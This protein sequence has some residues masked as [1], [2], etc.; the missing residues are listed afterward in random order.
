MNSV[1]INELSICNVLLRHGRNICKH[2][3][4]S[5]HPV[6][7]G[8]SPVFLVQVSRARRR[9]RRLFA[10]RAREQR[11]IGFFDRSSICWRNRFHFFPHSIHRSVRAK[12]R[13]ATSDPLPG[14]DIRLPWKAHPSDSRAPPGK[15]LNAVTAR[16]WEWAH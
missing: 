1:L 6:G 14:Y 8:L 16:G 13:T 11:E 7:N 9:S 15:M 4:G 12:S 2:W 10:A 3:Q 5:R